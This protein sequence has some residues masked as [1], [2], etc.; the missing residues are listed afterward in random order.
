MGRLNVVLVICCVA[1]VGCGQPKVQRY[2]S[3]IGV[4]EATLAEYKRIHADVWPEVLRQLKQSNIR[5][6][7]IYLHELEPDKYYL[8]GYFEY[9][10]DNFKAD[11][12]KMADD[13]TT[14]K[15]WKIT[16]PMQIPLDNRADGEWW[17][18][19]EELFHM[20]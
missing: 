12:A 7:S 11:M 16:D 17:A 8:F 18:T 20:N 13:P 19:M 5:N 15:W 4:K 10:G 3:V 2:S 6:Y 9:T 1:L 14:Q